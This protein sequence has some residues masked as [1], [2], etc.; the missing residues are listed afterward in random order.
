MAKGRRPSNKW[1]KKT[2]SPYA[3][4]KIKNERLKKKL[5]KKFKMQQ[6]NGNVGQR[7]WTKAPTRRQALGPPR[8]KNKTEQ[9]KTKKQRA[10][11][12]RASKTIKKVLPALE[13]RN[14]AVSSPRRKQY[15]ISI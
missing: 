14:N 6:E 9:E 15:T 3:K 1:T 5:T 2:D 8:K 12:W 13:R 10:N 11:K 4:E 7:I